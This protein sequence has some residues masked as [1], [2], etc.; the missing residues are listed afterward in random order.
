MDE[1][2]TNY[3]ITGIAL[4]QIASASV[5]EVII[6]DEPMLPDYKELYDL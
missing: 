2:L 6:S 1:V 4:G 3:L 5:T